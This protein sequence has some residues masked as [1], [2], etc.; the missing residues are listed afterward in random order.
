M[1]YANNTTTVKT[2]TKDIADTK[3]D[4]SSAELRAEKAKVIDLIKSQNPP[5]TAKE[6][7]YKLYKF[8]EN[9][10]VPS[11]PNYKKIEVLKYSKRGVTKDGPITPNVELEQVS[12]EPY[13]LP[14]TFEWSKFD[15]NTQFE[16]VQ[17]YD[18]LLKFLNRFY[19]EDPTS[20]FMDTFTVD[21]LKW[22]IG[23]SWTDTSNNICIGVVNKKDIVVGV[24]SGTIQQTQ[25]KQNKVDVLHVNLMCVHPSYRTKR[26]SPVLIKE[27]T[28]RA[29]LKGCFQGIFCTERYVP[30]PFSSLN[31]HHRPL[32]IEKLIDS[33]YTKLTGKIEVEELIKKYRLPKKTHNKNFIRLKED[34]GKHIE[35]ACDLLN[36]YLD[37]FM[38]HPV[39]SKE[40]FVVKFIGDSFELS[41]QSN[42]V[43]SYVLLDDKTDEV[44]DFVSY[45]TTTMKSFNKEQE[46]QTQIQV[47]HL[48][49]Y[50][51]T[52]ETAYRLVNDML[53]V[54]KNNGVDLFNATNALENDTFLK[55]LK[56]EE[57]PTTLNCN[58]FNWNV[59]DIPPQQIAFNF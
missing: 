11:I 22:M 43:V 20:K 37:K 36:R 54:A 55:E 9:Q 24:I 21:R 53:I 16:R 46:K 15:L 23:D 32:N 19:F 39:F 31:V 8:W 13:K 1:S 17:P 50:T 56:F 57:G 3:P 26:L 51:S 47:G 49:Y 25:I 2:T 38:V 42:Q 30:R 44:L 6:S 28:R 14:G 48:Y 5:K 52:V 18:N 27:I 33:N 7:Y 58:L 4:M 12:K 35:Q 29:N 41:S 10:P 40:E 34:D 59:L 45:Y